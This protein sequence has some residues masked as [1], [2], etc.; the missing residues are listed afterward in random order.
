MNDLYSGPIL[1]YGTR[2]R[3]AGLL[4]SPDFDHEAYNALCGDRLRLTVR[5]DTGQ[6]VAGVGWEYAGCA[7]SQAAASLLGDAILGRPLD[8]LRRLGRQDVLD[9][10]GVPVPANRVQCALLPLQV[11][12]VGLFG[13]VEWRKHEIEDDED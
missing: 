10:L 1:T 11:L 7:V 8:D 2:P 13:P 12:I 6:R 5:L 3:H 9:L 4:P